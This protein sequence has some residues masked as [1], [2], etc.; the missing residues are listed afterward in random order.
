M[1]SPTELSL[2]NASTEA[3]AP[4]EST[5]N[6]RHRPSSHELM[7]QLP[8]RKRSI[9]WTRTNTLV[10]RFSRPAPPQRQQSRP[11]I[12]GLSNSAFADILVRPDS[13]TKS[14]LTA[15]C[16]NF[17]LPG[18]C[19]SSQGIR[20]VTSVQQGVTVKYSVKDPNPDPAVQAQMVNTMVD[21]NYKIIW[22]QPID[23]A[24]IAA[25]VKRARNAG[26]VVVTINI[27]ANAQDA[28]FVTQNHTLLSQAVGTQMAKALGGKG[29]IY[30]VRRPRYINLQPA[31]EWL[32]SA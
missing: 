32:L 2:S 27:V 12:L 8:N 13:A 5:C 31:K 14:L 6:S 16:W 23:S 29:N 28:A 30:L 18:H 22:L 25:P 1:T 7:K 26:I 20:N 21:Q 15:F 24:A 17:K 19:A 4:G 3:T 10:V 11:P 9:T